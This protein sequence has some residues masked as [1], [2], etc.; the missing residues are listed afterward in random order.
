MDFEN[1]YTKEQGNFRREV[2]AWLEANIP[3]NMQM[4]TDPED[5]SEDM[6]WF[7]RQKHKEMAAKGWLFPTYPKEYGGGGLTGEH[8]T[9][10]EEESQRFRVPRH[11]CT[12]WI[13]PALLVWGTEEQKKKWLVPFL[14]GEQVAWE[15][16]TEPHSGSDLASYQSHAVREG[17]E[18]VI[19][20]AN[21]FVSGRH[22]PYP[23]WLY[24]PVVSDPDAPRHRNLAYLIIPY[25]TPGVEIKKLKLTNG[26]DQ[27]FVYLDNVRIPA[28][29]LIGNDHQGW[30]VANTSLEQEHGGRG[31]AFPSD[32]VV[33]NLIAYVQEHLK[34]SQSPGG[35]P[36]LQ[37]EAADA[38]IDGHIHNLFARR[39]YWMYMSRVEMSWEGPCTSLFGRNYGMRNVARVRDVMGP[40]ALL[41]T[42]DPI[43]P[44]GGGQEVDQRSSFIHQHGAGSRNINKVLLARRIG[45]SR[46]RERAAVT[47]M[48]AGRREKQQ[49]AD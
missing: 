16:F 47:P 35:D 15:K 12:D 48:T 23:D 5:F 27:H 44:C 11:F 21:V 7:W 6:Y 8:E 39:T 33:D 31:Q 4:P 45:I 3:E 29:H 28:D 22:A 20:G 34:K 30:Q 1:K 36:V 13:L 19:N 46:T 32:D 42:K 38:F 37:Q 17:D 9:I 41:G 18:W 25:P 24:G 40:Y 43:A 26:S 10:I 49:E 14:K 2:R